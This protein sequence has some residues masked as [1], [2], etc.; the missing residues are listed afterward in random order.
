MQFP[1][2]NFLVLA[3]RFPFKF[4][5]SYGLFAGWRAVYKGAC[6][7][8]IKTFPTS[9]YNIR[10]DITYYITH[11]Y[12][13]TP[14]TNAPG[15][16]SN[17][18]RRKHGLSN[19]K[20]YGVNQEG[21]NQKA[22]GSKREQI[23]KAIVRNKDN[24]PA[25]KCG[26]RQGDIRNHHDMGQKY[27]GQRGKIQNDHGQNGANQKIRDQIAKNQQGRGQSDAIQKDSGKIVTKLKRSG[28]NSANRKDRGRND[29][30]HKG[31]DENGQRQMPVEV[32]SQQPD[33][34]GNQ[35]HNNNNR[36]GD[37]GRKVPG[38][39]GAGRKVQKQKES[40]RSGEGR[41]FDNTEGH[42]VRIQR[43][44]KRKKTSQNG[45]NNTEFRGQD[46]HKRDIDG[47]SEN[48]N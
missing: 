38:R 39:K 7:A 31:R 40:H 42:D 4:L 3:C 16:E 2:N 17:K 34:A 9:S 29:A 36:I 48:D 14:T 25:P 26:E 28:Q 41:L 37:P 15:V 45:Q 21:R 46:R 1:S 44:F 11:F 18:I 8:S 22:P 23:H 47:H 27:R 6:N 5:L 35:V 12:G 33:I 32:S 13:R 19:L 30:N 24:R 20:Q 43:V 10:K